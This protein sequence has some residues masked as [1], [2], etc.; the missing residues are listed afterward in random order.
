MNKRIAVVTAGLLASTLVLAGCSDKKDETTTAPD[1]APSSTKVSVAPL[2]PTPSFAGSVGGYLKDVKIENC[3]TEAG[4]QKFAGTVTNSSAEPL[5][6]VI[7][8]MWLK[9]GD[10]T[11]YANQ[12]VLVKGVKAGEKRDF[13]G[14]ASV[15]IKVDVCWPQVLGG[16]LA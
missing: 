6:Y 14:E 3:G 7:T 13:S 10:S 2:S 15:P 11:P 9:N 1:A 12:Q 5:D 4:T 16:Q 8:V